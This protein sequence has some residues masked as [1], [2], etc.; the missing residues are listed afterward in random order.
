MDLLERT[1]HLEQLRDYLRQASGGEGKLVLL[2]GEA[3]IGKT[4]LVERFVR[5]AGAAVP[6][7]RAEIVSCDGL[8]MPGP[9][10]S[11]FEIAQVLGPEVERLLADE[12]PR[13]RLFRAVL[14]ALAGLK[15]SLVL[16]GEDAHWTDEASIDL[17]R[18]IGRRIGGLRLLFVVTYRDD[19]LGLSHPLRRILGDLATAPAVR[20]M[21]LPPLSPAAVRELVRGSGFDP[22]SLHAR[23]GGNPFF[24]TEVLAAGA[25]DVPA[26]VRDAVLARASRLSPEARAVLDAAAVIGEQVEPASAR[27][28]RRWSDR[29]CGR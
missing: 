23:T 7:I 9:L 11:L 17:I 22:D 4:T 16:V 19:E 10:G 27:S 25:P 12:A 6:P 8:K 3:G 1:A 20:R 18:F 14:A 26:T 21:T 2:G 5:E 13:D 29:G 24:V 28:G 15:Q